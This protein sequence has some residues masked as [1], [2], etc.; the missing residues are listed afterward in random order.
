MKK[1]KRICASLYMYIAE[2]IHTKSIQLAIILLYWQRI[3]FSKS[4]TEGFILWIAVYHD[5]VELM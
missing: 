1:I 5:I 3:H 4:T 2:E